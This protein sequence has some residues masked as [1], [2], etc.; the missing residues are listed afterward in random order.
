MQPIPSTTTTPPA[1]PQQR[2]RR[3]IR[4][5]E[6]LGGRRITDKTLQA[7]AIIERYRIIP[8]S[9]LVRLMP[10]NLRNNYDHLQLLFHK[11]LSNHFSLPK[12]GGPGEHIHYLDSKDAL[13]LLISE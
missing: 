1:Q 5:P 2:M 4:Q 6:K 7:L 9:F 13:D 11:G 12:Y 3:F 8:S 10:G